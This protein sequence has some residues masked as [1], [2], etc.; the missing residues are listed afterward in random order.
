MTQ[1]ARRIEA[2]PKPRQIPILVVVKRSYAYGWERRDVFA[3][4]Y[5]L[6]VALT[7]LG[8]L[9]QALSSNNKAVLVLGLVVYQ[10]FAMAFAVGIHRFVLLREAGRGGGFYCWDRH[11]TPYVLAALCLAGAAFVGLFAGAIAGVVIYGMIFGLPADQAAIAGA[12]SF[13]TISLFALAPIVLIGAS[14][15]RA[16]LILPAIAADAENGPG[17]VGRLGTIWRVSHHNGPRLFAIDLL[18]ALPFMAAQL[19]FLSML[20][21][22]PASPGLSAPV[23]LLAIALLLIAPLQIIVG[24]VALALQYDFLVRGNGPS[25]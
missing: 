7:F 20:F 21:A 19:I 10:I 22:A 15:C 8:N 24:N 13:S 1:P 17:I 12:Q 11:L 6:Y 23:F 5:W 9:L 14:L 2:S 18:V 4:P 16:A 3:R 25:A